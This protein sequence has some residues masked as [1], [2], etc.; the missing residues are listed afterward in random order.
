MMYATYSPEDNKLRLYSTKRLDAEQYARV[1]AEGFRWAPKQELFVAPMWTPSREDL[2]VELCGEIG[3]ED[4]SLVE[5]QEARAER[6]E[7]YSES[8]AKDAQNAYETSV[9]I[10]K[11]FEGGQPILVGHHSEKRARKDKERIDGAMRAAVKMWDTSKY[12]TDR[13]QGAIRHAKYKE[14]PD[15]RAR[16]IKTL[17]ADQ[18]KCQ[19]SKDAAEKGLK[20]WTLLHDDTLSGI[21]KKDGA[22]TTFAE[23][24]LFVAGHSNTASY[25]TYSGLS[26]GT[27]TP[28]EAQAQT[29]AMHERAKAHSE[30]WI[31]HYANRIAYERAML[32]EAGGTLEQQKGC[33]TGGA[34]RCWASPRGGW[35]YI[36]KVNK[37]TVTVLDNWGNGGRNFTRTIEFDKLAGIMT[38]A[39]V[40][41]KRDA[42]VLVEEASGLGFCLMD[43]KP[44]PTPQPEAAPA[45]DLAEG[46]D[47]MRDALKNGGVSV[48]V[49]PQ[50][51]PTPADLAARMVEL[52][53][54]EPGEQLLE[55]S[56][57]TGALLDAA[58]GTGAEILA[59][60][61]NPKLCDAVRAK[62]YH[63]IQADFLER[64]PEEWEPF[65]CVLMN[66]PFKNGEDIKHIRHA[67]TFLRPGG[68]L[69]AICA[70][71][72]RQN[73]KLKPLT[74]DGGSWEDLPDGTFSEAGTNVRTALI[75]LTVPEEE[76]E[77][78]LDAQESLETPVEREEPAFQPE[79]VIERVS[80]GSQYRL[81]L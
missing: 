4:T 55:P 16:R 9:S 11:R 56:A 42:G 14:R 47:A 75:T 66:P 61:I 12:W 18:R 30:R 57:G 46:I 54:L 15:V 3:D 67:L 58:K 38:A 78:Q 72:P 52:A 37:V 45:A 8:R 69:V 63:V 74:L 50:L 77:T 60:E 79:P 65:D 7:D 19:R 17:E 26:G 62:G 20:I 70:N 5:R 34:V 40:Q 59:L 76:G 53:E 6:F 31:A 71:G 35:S 81:F 2:L 41:A 36:Q 27:M 64:K 49:A 28:E 51:F 21:K 44:D 25:G 32:D 29:I 48:V 73:D 80:G 1:K 13:A 10:A 68:R 33:E 39:E 23:R 24:A 43:R 22:P